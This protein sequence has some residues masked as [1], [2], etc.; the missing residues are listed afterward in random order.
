LI[1]P[2]VTFEAIQTVAFLAHKI[3]NQ[4]YIPIIGQQQVDYM[5][6]KFQ[7]E[8]AINYQ[9]E[10]DYEY[11]ILEY[12]KKPCGYLALVPNNDEKKMMISKIYVDSDFRGLGLGSQLLEFAIEKTKTNAFKFLWLTVNKNNN[13]SINWYKNHGF[14]IKKELK[15]DIG[16]GFATD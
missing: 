5:L 11:F 15:I 1:K 13:K 16:N 6:D 9:I 8:E 4:H 14:I 10:N 12:Q 2:V 7:D 3:W